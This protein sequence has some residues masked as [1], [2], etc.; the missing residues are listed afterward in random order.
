MLSEYGGVR[1]FGGLGNGLLV[2]FSI[3]SP[4]SEDGRSSKSLTHFGIWASLDRRHL[5]SRPEDQPC[6]TCI[7]QFD[8][9]MEWAALDGSAALHMA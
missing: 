1:S 4:K 9:Q 7:L 2:G 3:V 5:F 6:A 8:Q